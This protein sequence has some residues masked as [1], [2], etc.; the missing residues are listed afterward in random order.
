[1]GEGGKLPPPPFPP[2]PTAKEGPTPYKGWALQHGGHTPFSLEYQI[3]PS[4]SYHIW[5]SSNWSGQPQSQP[6][7]RFFWSFFVF[8]VLIGGEFRHAHW[9]PPQQKEGNTTNINLNINSKMH[10][11]NISRFKFKD[12][13]YAG[14]NLSL[15][16]VE[17]ILLR[18]NIC[19]LQS[20][21]ESNI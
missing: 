7:A 20:Y 17:T 15:V 4:P 13:G 10:S 21:F 18:D 2:S 5:Y 14:D 19:K 8:P 12:H 16:C 1:M 9:I 6:P 11:I 3:Q